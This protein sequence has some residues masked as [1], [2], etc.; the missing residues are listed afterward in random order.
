MRHFVFAKS[1]AKMPS[2]ANRSCG[3]LL[4]DAR[5]QLVGDIPFTQQ[6]LL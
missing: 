6:V 5:S 4:T 2:M 3:A 1:V